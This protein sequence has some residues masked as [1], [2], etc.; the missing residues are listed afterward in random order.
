M[1]VTTGQAA[2]AL[3][4][5]IPLVKKLIAS[6]AVPG[7]ATQ[8][9]QVFPL[10]GLQALESAPC[11]DLSLLP[12]S[13]AA[14]LRADVASPSE[15]EDRDWIGYR[16]DLSPGQLTDALSGWWRCDPGRVATGG[17]LVVTV[18]EFVVAVLADL[19]SPHD[20]GGTR[21]TLRYK[22]P[23]ARLAGWLTDLT[24]VSTAQFPTGQDPAERLLV[25]PLLGTRLPS[26]SGGPI[27]YVPAGPAATR[28]GE[29]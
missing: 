26:T 28:H 6:G 9:R 5:S 15:E 22:F 16:A 14:V 11:C 3:G 8:G 7:V 18:A 12:E 17:L 24:D 21:Q 10:R 20:N 19:A 13:E 4:V 1:L 23:Q 2:R 25:Q 29:C 27:A